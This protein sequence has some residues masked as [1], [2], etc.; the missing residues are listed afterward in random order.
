MK[1]NEKQNEEDRQDGGQH[2][3]EEQSSFAGGGFHGD[4]GG[5]AE[6]GGTSLRRRPVADDALGDAVTH[7]AADAVVDFLEDEELAARIRRT[8]RGRLF[9]DTAVALL[10]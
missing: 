7:G 8:E 9:V 4:S 2:A 3:D 10:Q 1:E 5:A 6:S